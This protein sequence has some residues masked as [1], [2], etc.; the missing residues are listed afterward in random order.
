MNMTP[1]NTNGPALTALDVVKGWHKR[2]CTADTSLPPDGAAHRKAMLSHALHSVQ[3]VTISS[4]IL[5][6]IEAGNATPGKTV[7]TT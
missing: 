7:C 3:R 6:I 1:G 5:G 2:N 4:D